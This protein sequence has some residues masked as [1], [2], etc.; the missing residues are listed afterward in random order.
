ML[1]HNSAYLD[2]GG[3]ILVGALNYDGRN[4]QTDRGCRSDRE[5]GEPHGRSSRVAVRRLLGRAAELAHK[6]G[7]TGTGSRQLL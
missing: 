3:F 4:A 7:C 6:R 5:E 2:P 1:S